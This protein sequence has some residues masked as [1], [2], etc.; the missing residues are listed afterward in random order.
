MTHRVTT[1]CDG[2][3]KTKEGEDQFEVVY[4]PLDMRGGNIVTKEH[5]CSDCEPPEC[6]K[7]EHP[8]N[9]E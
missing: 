8:L 4:V 6:A 7:E 9:D 3:G 5:Y 2:C 1:E